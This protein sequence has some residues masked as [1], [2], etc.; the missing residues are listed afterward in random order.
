[1]M[2]RQITALLAAL[3]VAGCA[4]HGTSTT[5]APKGAKSDSA[6]ATASKDDKN[7][8]KPYDKVI[9][10]KAV[11]DSGVFE[12]HKVGDKTYYEIPAAMLGREFLIVSRIARTESG[13]GYGGAE[14]GENT[15]RFVR[16]D[17]KLYM[18]RVSFSTVA[19]TNTPIAQ[20]VRNSNFEPIVY[21]FD[22]KAYGPDS[23]V[24]IDVDPLYTKDVPMLGLASFRRTQYKVRR[25]DDSRTYLKSIHSYPRNIETRAVLTYDAAEPPS[26]QSTGSISMEMNHSMVLL[27]EKPMMPRLR[28]DRVGYF[29]INQTDYSRPEQRSVVRK[30]IARWRL[31]PKDTAAF[32]RGELVEPVKQIV[33]YIDRATPVKWRPYL[34][35]GIKDWNVAFEAA[36]FK[37]AITARMA[38]TPEEDPEFSPED[39]RYSMIR[40]LASDVENASGP[41]ISDPRS[42]E[43]LETHIQWYHNVMNLLRNWYMIQTAAVNPSARH[44]EFSDSVMGELIRFVSSHEVGH[45]LGLPHNMKASS[46]YPVDSLRSPS[47]TRKYHTA[48]SIMDY[49][50]FNYVA[51]PG[52]GDVTLHP[53][54]GPYD[55]YS[56]AWGYRPILDAATPDAEVPTLD[57]WIQ[58]KAG[59]PMYRFGDANGT[60][61]GAQTEDLGDNG[62]KA[63]EYGI[64]NLKRILPKL[65]EYSYQP[66]ADYSQLQELYGEVATQWNR[67]MGHVATIIGG[68]YETRKNSEQAGA[69][70]QAVDGAR[71]RSAAAFM[72]EQGLHTPSWLFDP[73]ILD[74]I[75][76]DGSAEKIKG[77][78]VGVLNRM[79]D[80]TRLARVA[81]LSTTAD[82]GYSLPDYLNDIGDGVWTE[83]RTGEA[84]DLYRRAL[85]RAWIERMNTL[86][87][88][89]LPPYP[90]AFRRLLPPRPSV[91]RSD[92]R[93][94]VRADL[95][96]VEARLRRA[97]QRGD[98]MTRAH[99][100]DAAARID[101]ILNP[102]K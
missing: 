87:T 14:N 21:G 22:V 90:A 65:M 91:S 55:K 80:P 26:N 100:A 61:P 7:G 95:E 34:I 37:N 38:P 68:I 102:N 31:E 40:Y 85:Q 2:S 46:S 28:D 32:R 69:V 62:V 33:Y 51:Q 41:H 1:M 54:I 83:L 29:G 81:D 52:D 56:I 45:T 53:G 96:S 43:I 20:A 66:H 49:A 98:A 84:P 39:A 64:A 16:N 3:T 60:D 77:L 18:R 23:S 5:P 30:Y 42:G 6:S 19:D 36:G 72:I 27:P 9:T 97:A 94:L 25:L 58:E 79:T 89:D 101:Q 67:Y 93:P 35:Q 63:G 50:R 71:Q 24:V 13:M 70:Y 17:N 57:K 10:A 75:G 47:F 12:V 99:Y 88:T 44:V 73:E 86:M 15:V 74:R 92:I 4:G 76:I 8:P 78:M 11:T 82:G 59:D 48:P